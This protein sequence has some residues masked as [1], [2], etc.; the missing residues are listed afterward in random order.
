MQ[1]NQS[2]LFEPCRSQRGA[3]SSHQTGSCSSYDASDKVVKRQ[4]PI[5]FSDRSRYRAI[6]LISSKEVGQIS[7]ARLLE[8]VGG[9]LM[10]LPCRSH[11]SL[12]CRRSSTHPLV[13]SCPHSDMPT[14]CLEI[15]SLANQYLLLCESPIRS[16][17]C[18][19]GH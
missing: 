15:V 1:D 18:S 14:D 12:G 11:G 17:E 13:L 2:D 19:H 10:R 5:F 16:Q 7:L 8:S 4:S 3:G 6:M 9:D